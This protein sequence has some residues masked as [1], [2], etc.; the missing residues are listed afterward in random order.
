MFLFL[1]LSFVC[2]SDTLSSESGCKLAHVCVFDLTNEDCGPGRV[3]APNMTMG[4]CCPGCAIGTDVGTNEGSYVS[5]LKISD[6][7]KFLCTY[8]SACIILLDINIQANLLI[9][10]HI[11]LFFYQ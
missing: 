11:Y 6:I 1:L 2:S 3:V 10:I 8:A 5:C 7:E 9:I 4:G